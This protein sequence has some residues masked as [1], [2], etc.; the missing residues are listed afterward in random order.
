MNVGKHT[1]SSNRNMTE[2]LVEFFIVANSELKM[3]WDDAA[4]FVVAARVSGELQNLGTEVFQNGGEVDGGAPA[5]IRVAYL[6]CRRYLP[7]RP[8]GN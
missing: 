2:H 6:P 1:S 7:I 5:P 8:T 4:S 3:P